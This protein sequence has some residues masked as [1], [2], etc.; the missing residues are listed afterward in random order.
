M[1]WIS[2]IVN[3]GNN[4]LWTYILII[5]LIVAG[6]YFSF[7]T[8]FVQIRLFPEMFRLIVEKERANQ[9]YHR[10]KLLLLVLLHVSAQGILQVLP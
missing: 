6:L 9:V 1:E 3:S 10:S 2:S 5:L 4:V 8:K 7:G